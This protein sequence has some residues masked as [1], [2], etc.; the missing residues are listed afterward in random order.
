[1]KKLINDP[2]A[3]VDESV[4]GFGLAHADLVTVFPDPKYIVRKDAPVAGKVGLV[5]GGGSGHEPLHGGYVGMGMLDAAVPGAVFT[6][7][8]PDQILPAT[9]AVNLSVG[10]PQ[11]I[12]DLQARKVFFVIGNE[13]AAV[14]FCVSSVGSQINPPASCG[15]ALDMQIRANQRRPSQRVEDT[16][17]GRRFSRYSAAY[18]GAKAGRIRALPIAFQRSFLGRDVHGCVY[19]SSNIA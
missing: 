18:C 1:M 9:L 15:S 6:S 14:R 2:K 10:S 13:D 11:R 3:V 7:P 4:E 8:T 5:S 19:I 12:D 17:L 16:P